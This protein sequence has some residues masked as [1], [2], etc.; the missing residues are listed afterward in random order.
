[1]PA[2]IPLVEPRTDRLLLRQWRPA[3]RAGFAALNADPEVMRHFPATLTE[4]ES[5]GFVDRHAARL[6]HDGY[7]LWAVEVLATGDFIGFVGLNRPGWDAHFTPCT[8]VGWR[9]ARH[10][11]GKGYASEAASGSLDVAFGPLGLGEVV[12]FTTVGNTRSRAVMHRLGMT[13]TEDFDHPNLAVGHPMRRHVLYR[14]SNDAWA[15]RT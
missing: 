11:W 12:S 15:A 13:H 1:V 9:L 3:D 5:N 10:A 6:E 2:R 8:E 4:E 14:L 7:G